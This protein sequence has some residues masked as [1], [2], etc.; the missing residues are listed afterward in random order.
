MVSFPEHGFPSDEVR[1]PRDLAER[2][3]L[4]YPDLAER[5]ERETGHTLTDE[6]PLTH[7]DV[8]RCLAIFD[9]E[10]LPDYR[11]HAR[12]ALKSLR[13][14][15][16]AL[17]LELGDVLGRTMQRGLM[18]PTNRPMTAAETR[19]MEEVLGFS[20]DE[21]ALAARL[22]G[23]ASE[24]KEAADRLLLGIERVRRQ[25]RLGLPV[26]GPGQDIAGGAQTP[27]PASAPDTS[28]G[29]E[30]SPRAAAASPMPSGPAASA[31]P[32]QTPA[33]APRVL[34]PM[35]HLIRVYE[36]RTGLSLDA[37][38][39][40]PPHGLPEKGE[41]C[42]ADIA[43]LLR[44]PPRVLLSAVR[45]ESG[46]EFELD[47]PLSY[48]QS[49]RVLMLVGLWPVEGLRSRFQRLPREMESIS[50][51]FQVPR[52][53]IRRL[54]EQRF[55]VLLPL[56]ARLDR[57]QVWMV[58]EAV[59]DELQLASA[60]EALQAEAKAELEQ[61]RLRIER[62]GRDGTALRRLRDLLVGADG[63]PSAS[64]AAQEEPSTSA[65]ALAGTSAAAQVL[66]DIVRRGTLQVAQTGTSLPFGTTTSAT[67]ASATPAS[68]TA[69]T[70]SSAV[71]ASST[72][73]LLGAT[74]ATTTGAA[75]PVQPH[76]SALAPEPSGPEEDEPDYWE[77]SPEEKLRR[78]LQ[79]EMQEWQI[80]DELRW[81]PDH[82]EAIEAE[83][84]ARSGYLSPRQRH[85]KDAERFHHEKTREEDRYKFVARYLRDAADDPNLL[86]A[87]IDG[88]EF[89]AEFYLRSGQKGG[90]RGACRWL[91]AYSRA[92][93]R[94]IAEAGL[95]ILLAEMQPID[96]SASQH[97]TRELGTQAGLAILER[98]AELRMDK[99]AEGV[100]YAWKGTEDEIFWALRDYPREGPRRAL[101]CLM[102]GASD[103]YG[104]TRLDPALTEEQRERLWADILPMLLLDRGR[105]TR[106]RARIARLLCALPRGWETSFEAPPWRTLRAEIKAYNETLG[107][108]ETYEEAE[109]PEDLV[110]RLRGEKEDALLEALRR[111]WA[112]HQ[113]PAL[114]LIA[115]A[116]IRIRDASVHS[117][118]R[119]RVEA[120]LFGIRALERDDLE[121]ILSLAGDDRDL[122]WA[123]TS[124]HKSDV[125]IWR[126]AIRRRPY[127]LDIL[128]CAM[129]P[130][131]ARAD[132]TIRGIL[133]ASADPHVLYT[134][135]RARFPGVVHRAV[136][137]LA[138]V[139]VERALRLIELQPANLA[140]VRV[141]EEA[142]AKLLSHPHPKVRE[143]AVR[144]YG[145]D[146]VRTVRG[147]R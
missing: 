76:A 97:I 106:R 5:V 73:R 35:D 143:R 21:A 53:R 110:A 80:P 133:L 141:S 24:T 56:D 48:R 132:E 26:P 81:H 66:A 15:A 102:R 79:G 85:F 121:S 28:V 2:L 144:L 62:S 22:A 19:G 145:S 123:L 68:A 74:A 36:A 82:I 47:E 3:G 14:L 92:L 120:L 122:L 39:V 9:L 147:A 54:V 114:S 69:G 109:L 108:G 101:A 33:H 44:V 88:D 111:C 8:A 134:L 43:R 27:V 70:A 127:D 7:E 71:V 86:H 18:I 6:R 49:W 95:E 128:G 139:D 118:E 51:Q 124:H 94:E 87:F 59:G 72:A 98:A 142:W 126:E 135:A 138:E 23:R 116:V 25:N 146:R 34:Y 90:I 41:M 42:V 104:T 45:R 58:A 67:P 52:F 65:I 84:D 107:R 119:D 83:I 63:E 50:E 60:V 78:F 93:R 75:S 13:I 77:L 137:A 130:R 129:F 96:R 57:D 31:T 91:P 117:Y 12:E 112:D 115:R 99:V 20:L 140:R 136:E 89:L 103:E 32:R 61:L 125:S 17:D 100:G 10:P 105:E 11:A 113:R 30:P 37:I 16:E 40:V 38:D 4:S 64:P 131:A 1:T 55:G 46:M 29:Q